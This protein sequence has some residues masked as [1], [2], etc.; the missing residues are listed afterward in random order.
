[1]IRPAKNQVIVDIDIDKKEKVKVHEITIRRKSG[2]QDFT[3]LKQCDE[4]N[5]R[6]R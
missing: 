6:K 2:H 3:K 4:E 1:M 5:Q